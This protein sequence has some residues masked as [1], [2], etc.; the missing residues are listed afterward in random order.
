MLQKRLADAPP[1]MVGVQ[2][3]YDRRSNSIA[4]LE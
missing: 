4:A 1:D 2:V 3:Y